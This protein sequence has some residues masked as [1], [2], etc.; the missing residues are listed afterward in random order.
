[1]GTNCNCCQN[2]VVEAVPTGPLGLVA[3]RRG[4]S[5]CDLGETSSGQSRLRI[6]ARGAVST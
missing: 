3:V 6:I 4:I 5:P 2:G 1:M